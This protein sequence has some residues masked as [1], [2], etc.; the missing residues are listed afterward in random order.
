MSQPIQ[1]TDNINW[2]S[3]E[4]QMTELESQNILTIWTTGL[5]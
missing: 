1:R 2:R 5:D 3:T 4:Y